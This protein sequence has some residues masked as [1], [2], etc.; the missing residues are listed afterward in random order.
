MSGFWLEGATW[1]AN[2]DWAE[3]LGHSRAELAVEPR[4]GGPDGGAALCMKAIGRRSS[5]RQH[6]RAATATR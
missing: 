6:G 1:R 4:G 5:F 3:K 2:P